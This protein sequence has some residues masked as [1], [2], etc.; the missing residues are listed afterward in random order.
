MLEHNTVA[1]VS[2]EGTSSDATSSDTLEDLLDTLESSMLDASGGSR[3]RQSQDEQSLDDAGLISGLLTGITGAQIPGSNP[4]F[5]LMPFA[6][7]EACSLTGSENPR[8]AAYCT[9]FLQN[10]LAIPLYWCHRL[11]PIRATMGTGVMGLLSVPVD[12][13]ESA[14]MQDFMEYLGLDDAHV[15]SMVKE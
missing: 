8:L 4:M 13:E 10:F 14:N 9:N 1:T 12:G 15:E 6:M 11:L 5:P 3:K 2:I 7:L